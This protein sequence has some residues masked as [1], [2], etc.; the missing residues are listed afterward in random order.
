MTRFLVA[1]VVGLT[2]V[3]GTSETDGIATASPG[4]IPEHFSVCVTTVDADGR[5]RIDS[6]WYLEDEARIR[7]AEILRDGWLTP[8]D[9]SDRE[10]VYP[11]HSIVKVTIDPTLL[12]QGLCRPPTSPE[13][14]REGAV[15]Q[16]AVDGSAVP[17]QFAVCVTTVDAQYARRDSFWSTDVDAR[18]RRAEILRDGWLTSGDEPDREDVY[19]PHAIVKATIDDVFVN[20]PSC[21]APEG[22]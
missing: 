17:A 15:P 18:T 2:A 10:D 19:P 13:P 7:R 5:A 21:L 3:A 22:E 6:S 20:Q 16:A 1:A 12:N 8:G 14:D 11:V 9:E 4:I